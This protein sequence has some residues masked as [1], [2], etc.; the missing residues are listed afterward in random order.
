MPASNLADLRFAIQTAKGTPAATSAYGLFLAG[1]DQP[2][3]VPTVDSFAETS[4]TRMRSDR[5]LST[6]T[7]TGAPQFYVMPKMA[8]SLLYAALGA[9]TTT[10]ASDPYTHTI[11]PAT[12]TPWLTFWRM[13]GG[14]IA[15]RFTDCKVKTVVIHGETGRPLTM[16][17]TIVGLTPTFDA[18]AGRETTAAI[19]IAD[20]FMHY[21]GAGALLVEGA[22]DNTIRS[23][24]LTIENNTATVPGVPITPVDAVEGELS[25]TLRATTLF[26]TAA[27]RN[28]LYYGSATPADDAGITTT[29]LELAGSP[30]GVQ[31][32]FTR[33]AAAPGPERSLRIAIPRITL[34]PFDIQP[35]TGNEPLTAEL[36]MTALQ[37]AGATSA[38]TATVKNGQATI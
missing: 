32:T 23:F 10:G 4:A 12:A 5:Y 30:V 2:H 17:V 6:V 18:Y 35:S 37:P 34:D 16:T 36:M 9:V 28:R 8:A 3:P 21:D 33:V 20:R 13:V 11:I 38:I 27:L 7:A 1:G 25:I 24:D 31:F 14:L 29:L 15:E 19:E 22:V 26:S